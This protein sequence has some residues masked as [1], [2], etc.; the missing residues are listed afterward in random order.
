MRNRAKCMV[1]QDIIESVHV[2]DYVMCKCGQIAVDG[3]N[4]GTWRAAAYEWSNFIRID[5]EGNEVTPKI[6][7]KKDMEENPK[8]MDVIHPKDPVTKEDRLQI[9]NDMILRCENLPE[10]AMGSP[11]NQYDY[12]SLLYMMRSILSV[13]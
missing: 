5:D 7:E 1:C 3:G 8:T 9:L 4:N 10:A 11:L 12:L 13:D 2:H 6:V